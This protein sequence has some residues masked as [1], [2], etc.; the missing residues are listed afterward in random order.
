MK[1]TLN[2]KKI[3]FLAKTFLCL[4][5]FLFNTSCGLDVL[6]EPIECPIESI[7]RPDTDTTDIPLRSF[8]FS[9]K[10]LTGYDSIYHSM[11]TFIYYKI[12]NKKTLFDDETSRI[13]SISDDSVNKDRSKY[14]LDDYKYQL[15]KWSKVNK[16]YYSF[17]NKDQKIEVRLESQYPYDSC[18]KI[19][20]L[21]VGIPIRYNGKSF[22]FTELPLKTDDDTVGF[23]DPEEGTTITSY[24][25]ALYA[26]VEG[27]DSFYTPYYSPV[28]YLGGITIQ[29]ENK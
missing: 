3:G 9:I 28:K 10:E 1:K 24:Y 22:D 19:A 27:Y 11:N 23:V 18:V 2:I 12:Y 4:C 6:N 14:R 21:N 8:V 15:L 25:I 26:V 16:E 17:E 7:Q 20:D 13:N 5:L 29:T